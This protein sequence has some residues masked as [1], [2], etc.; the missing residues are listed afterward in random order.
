MMRALVA[1]ALRLRLPVVALAVSADRRRHP[2]DA[3]RRF[4]VFPEFAPPLVEIQT[5]APG[6][7]SAD[8]EALISVPLEAAH[9]RRARPEDAAVEVGARAVVGGADLRRRHRP[10]GGAAAGAG[11]SDPRRSDPA[12]RGAAAGDPVAAVVAQPG[13]EDRR[14]VEDAVAD[15]ADDAGALDDPAAADGDSRRRQRR[16]LGA[17]RSPAAGARRS[18][19]AA[20][21]RRLAAGRDRRD[22]RRHVGRGRRLHRDAQPAPGGRARGAGQDRGGPGAHAACAEAA[23]CGDRSAPPTSPARRGAARAGSVRRIGDVADV[24]EGFPPPIGDGIINDGP[25]CC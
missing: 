8:V 2:D 24:V 4:D 22:A 23:Q 19:S 5:E 1:A 6:L 11:A 13:D 10:H 17:A 12:R 20:G 3:R 18:R 25:A 15:R 14:V 16:D 7:S 21:Q 9:E